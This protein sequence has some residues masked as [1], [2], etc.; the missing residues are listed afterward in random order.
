MAIQY[1]RANILVNSQTFSPNG[2][3]YVYGITLSMDAGASWVDGMSV[4]Y[5]A[6]ALHGNLHPQ[7]NIEEFLDADSI[8]INWMGFDWANE[9]IDFQII[10]AIS[11]AIGGNAYAGS[12]TMLILPNVYWVG[13][14]MSWDTD[15]AAARS[16]T[17]YVQSVP[18]WIGL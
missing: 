16:N 3:G 9:K 15:K 5:T 13:A 7:L 11:S 10:P 18:V 17:F 6:L 2:P 14:G 1:N 4:D 8:P 12:N